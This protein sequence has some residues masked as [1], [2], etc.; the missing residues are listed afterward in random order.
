[1]NFELNQYHLQTK[2]SYA[3]IR[4]NQNYMDWNNQPDVFKYYPDTFLKTKLDLRIKNHKFVHFISGLTAKK[5]YPGVEYYLRVNPSAGALFPNEIYFQ[6]RAEVGF[7]DGIYHYQNAT[8]QCTLLQSIKDD[9]IES[10]MG[11]DTK[12]DGFIFLISS[13]YFRSSWKYK[14]RAFRY[15]LL[16]SGHLLGSIEAST[17]LFKESYKILYDFDKAGLNKMFGFKNQEFFLAGMVLGTSTQYKVEPLQ[18]QL[19]FV[20]C[21]GTFEENILIEEAYKNSITLRGKV[22]QKENPIFNFHQEV[23]EEAVLKRRSIREFTEKS[24]KKEEFL[25][26]MS[27]LNQPCTSDC[28]E[29]V[30]IYCV[31]NRVDD[32]KTGLYKNGEYIKIGFFHKE[33]GY[34]CLEQILGSQSAVTFFLISKSHNYQAMY[35][36]AGIIGQRLYLAASYLNIGCTGIGA[37]YDDEV[38]EFLDVKDEMVLYALAIGN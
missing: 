33:A 20:D 38:L 32:M 29:E 9:G 6:V 14:N 4:T 30:D 34:L 7:E 27:I 22:E 28:D 10:M 26:V 19:P 36:K 11:F 1:M 21:T 25:S 13:P 2:H 8:S 3:S 12:Q 17:Y 5:S 37:Y 15:C 16:D 23:F 35:Q 31:I 18:M 24:I